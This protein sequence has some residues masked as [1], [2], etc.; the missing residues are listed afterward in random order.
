VVTLT[1]G[2][3]IPDRDAVIVTVPTLMPI[4]SP[5]DNC[6]NAAIVGSELVQVTREL[7]SAV[8]PSE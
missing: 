8:V 5:P 2:L 7:I 4:N 3:V 6:V 1:V